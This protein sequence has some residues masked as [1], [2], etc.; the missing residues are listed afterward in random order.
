MVK[1]LT[2]VLIAATVIA[3]FLNPLYTIVAG[4]M[5]S[6]MV[7]MMRGEQVTVQITEKKVNTKQYITRDDLWNAY[8]E[9][10]Q[11]TLDAQQSVG[12]R[13]E[14]IESLGG[15]MGPFL[16]VRTDF[17]LVQLFKIAED[18]EFIMMQDPRRRPTVTQDEG[19]P[20]PPLDGPW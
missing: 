1:H 14:Y 12:L 11:K 6:A 5:A 18:G 10:I 2:I 4:L 17:G 16:C 3:A 9:G 15:M 8:I 20:P 19:P 7:Y 13:L